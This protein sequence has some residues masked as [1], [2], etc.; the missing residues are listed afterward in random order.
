MT[1]LLENANETVMQQE[2][3]GAWDNRSEARRE[4]YRQAYQLASKIK[5]TLNGILE[6]QT[7]PKTEKSR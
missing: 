2:W 5:E 3:S 7:L 6:K 4:D 1:L